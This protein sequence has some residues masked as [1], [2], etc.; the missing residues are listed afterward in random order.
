MQLDV[1]V[2]APVIVL[3]RRTDSTDHMR[4]HLGALN[5]SN[6]VSQALPGP[7]GEVRLA[8]TGRVSRTC[9]VG[10]V[11]HLAVLLSMLGLSSDGRGRKVCTSSCSETQHME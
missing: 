8:R 4:V 1:D 9:I 7:D 2:A 6:T 5:L 11:C 3:P 10:D